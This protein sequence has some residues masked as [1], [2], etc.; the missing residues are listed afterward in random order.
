MIR[1]CVLFS[2]CVVREEGSKGEG[3]GRR[4]SFTETRKGVCE[5]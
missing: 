1:V 5:T 4:E 3:M 2:I